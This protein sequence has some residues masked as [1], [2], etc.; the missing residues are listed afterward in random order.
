MN[1]ISKVW[2]AIAP[3]SPAAPAATATSSTSSMTADGYRNANP[4]VQLEPWQIK[5][6]LYFPNSTWRGKEFLTFAR[7]L[8]PKKLVEKLLLRAGE[9]FSAAEVAK[10]RDLRVEQDAIHAKLEELNF[11][12]S[13]RI[14]QAQQDVA[15]QK[16]LAGD[17]PDA[18][19]RGKLEIRTSISA[20]REALH[21]ALLSLG[22]KV[23]DLLSPMCDRLRAVARDMAEAQDAKERGLHESNV[24]DE[25]PFIP[26][27]YLKTLA[28][29]ALHSCDAPVRNF[30]LT[31]RLH[32][33]DPDRLLDLWFSPVDNPPARPTSPA[34]HPQITAQRNAAAVANNADH[35]SQLA[36][37]NALTAKL[38]KDIQDT[39]E[40]AE[41]HRVKT[42]LETETRN[43]ALRQKLLDE[44]AAKTAEP[45]T[46]A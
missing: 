14:Y 34:E 19:L 32:C 42:A 41:L 35:K 31:K 12:A 33:P 25:Q 30:Y 1:I 28:F 6:S 27:T 21:A 23:F 40:Q 18:N 26:S 4:G 8:I 29:I 3:V 43:A 10:L 15:A 11:W 45:G 7:P 13:T 20:A 9:V 5:F 46:P 24:G 2:N 16:L 22:Q 38:Q 39:A 17:L 44:A 37:K 36:E